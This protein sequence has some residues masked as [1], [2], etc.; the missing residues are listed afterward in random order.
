[1]MVH[2]KYHDSRPSLGQEDFF[3]VIPIYYVKHVTGPFL[4][5]GV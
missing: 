4:A 5:P 3:H 2:T 1:M